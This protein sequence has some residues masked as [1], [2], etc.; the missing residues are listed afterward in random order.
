MGRLV[1]LS[2]RRFGLLSVNSYAGLDGGKNASW[3][4]LCDCGSP[5][6]I[7]GARMRDGTTASCGCL[8]TNT[9]ARKGIQRGDGTL[10]KGDAHRATYATWTSMR[11]RCLSVDHPAYY[12][13]GARGI[14]ICQRWLESFES[15]LADMGIR[16]FPGAELDRRDNAGNYSPSNCRWVTTKENSRNRRCVRI[17]D[18]PIGLMPTWKAVELSGLSR[19][20]I[21]AR[22]RY[23]WSASNLFNPLRKSSTSKVI[24]EHEHPLL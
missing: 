17:V 12:K 8:L 7:R 19:S 20:V 18:T 22:V 10:G 15:F 4:C 6:V 5:C 3:N 9:E 11:A 16:P 1:D 2:G 13:Y 24:N 23:K 21:D 14:T